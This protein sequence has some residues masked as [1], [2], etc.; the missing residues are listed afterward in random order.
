MIRRGDGMTAGYLGAHSV[1]ESGESLPE[2]YRDN[3]PGIG[4]TVGIT[5][6]RFRGGLAE[7]AA[8][9]EAQI[10]DLLD[11]IAVR[12]TS[13]ITENDLDQH[14]SLELRFISAL[15]PGADQIGARAAV[16]AR[17]DGGQW[18]FNA[19]LPFAIDDYAHEISADFDAQDWPTAIAQDS[20]EEMRLLCGKADRVLELAN[21]SPV[22]GH[23]FAKRWAARRY[24][25]IGSMLV[26]Q[27]DLL[28]ALW[29]GCP[30]RGAG[31]TADVVKEARASGVP[32]IWL[33]ISKPR[34]TPRSIVPQSESAHLLI[35]D[36]LARY[37]TG[38]EL[39]Q[40]SLILG[41]TAAI[42]RAMQN[43]LLG[44]DQKR[45]E[46]VLG[47]VA[48]EKTPLWDK[49]T[50]AAPEQA[51]GTQAA[52]YSL[53]LFWVLKGSGT[54]SWPFQRSRRIR[55]SR[56]WWPQIWVQTSDYSF[57]SKLRGWRAA[58]QWGVKKPT[59]QELADPEQEA[60]KAA[61]ANDAPL[62]V[63]TRRAD[64]I[65]SR[66]GHH[67]R[68]IYVAIFLLA[69]VA[70]M[71]ALA[72]VFHADGKPWFVAL[73]IAAVAGAAFLF[74]RAS[75]PDPIKKPFIKRLNTHQRWMDARLIAESQRAVQVLSWI[76][77]SGRRPVEE[78]EPAEGHH[79]GKEHHAEPR[80]IW[81][82]HF[83][84]A[85]AALP[86]FPAPDS[87]PGNVARMDTARIQSLAKA[88]R[89]LLD[90][91]IS[92][93]HN[94]A[95]RLKAFHHRL[96]A[97]GV[98]ALLIAF[99]VSATY[100][101]AYGLKIEM[102]PPK[103]SFWYDAYF[104]WKSVASFAGG[105]GPAV[106]AAAAGIRYHGD[107]E[108]FATRSEETTAR[109]LALT[110]RADALIALDTLG[111][112]WRNGPAAPPLFEELATLCLDTQAVLDEDLADWRFAYAA[113]PLMMG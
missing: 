52:L 99:V 93:H 60:V 5:G 65:A 83:A 37:N 7:S 42:G 107:F 10:R 106:A 26:R 67:Y 34:A 24:A 6:H 32:V 48:K 14:R 97:I 8:P 75:P 30:P 76:G 33:D 86:E 2:S 55:W 92:Y 38:D 103:G 68:S 50:K 73:E 43:V 90:D 15:A 69:A 66:L 88:L 21:W 13:A 108:R 112:A 96:D 77:F 80:V 111:E 61:T 64:A 58:D 71:F 62:E 113:R 74:W 57:N 36:L 27:S 39:A 79:D 54:R 20:V 78:P 3:L 95:N 19:I 41:E 87:A 46:A 1:E 84:N 31:G 91:Q 81:T 44:A 98:G 47:Y 63:P 16:R 94:N 49:G 109:L 4:F 40:R 28:I 72:Y 104:F 45:A 35:S 89:G 53:M 17:Q 110:V 56:W 51:C 82:P 12:L 11:A 85:I 25:T 59:K 23:D 22:A 18:T 70:V 100:L 9:F 102:H 105:V 101:V 29:D